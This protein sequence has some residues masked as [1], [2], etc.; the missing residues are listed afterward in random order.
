[1]E[2]KITHE[3]TIRIFRSSE[4]D[5]YYYDIYDEDVT[6]DDAVPL[7]GGFCTTTMQN[8]L[9]MALSQTVITEEE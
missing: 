5:G 2:N 1:M 8:A 9:E 3:L 4:G 6:N 7:D